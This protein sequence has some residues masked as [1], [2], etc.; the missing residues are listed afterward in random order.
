MKILNLHLI[1]FGP[2]TDTRLDLS[3]GTEGLHVIY[4]PNEAGKSSTLRGLRQMLFGI[5]DRS[6]DD[7]IH[8]YGKLRIGGA[9]RRSSGDVLDFIRRKGR[10]KTLRG[11]DDAT[12]LD[13][14]L[15][16]SFLAGVDESLFSTM[17]GIDHQG[18]V[19]GGREIING[20]GNVG[21]ILFAAGSGISDFQKVRAELTGEADDLFKPSA[22]VPRINA[23]IAEFDALKKALRAAQLP[24]QTWADHDKA[25]RD[26][27][28]RRKAVEDR[29]AEKQR[30]RNRLS[31]ITEALP[32]ISRREELRTD[33]E[34]Q[35]DA[36]LLPEDFSERRRKLFE[37]L[38]L[39]ESREEHASVSLDR[40]RKQVAGISVPVAVIER[41]GR[42]R[43]LFQEAGGVRKNARERIQLDGHRNRL[44]DDA[45]EIL[46]SLHS[47]R[48]LD[49]V[50]SLRPK[51]QD[52]RRIQELGSRFERLSTRRAA[53]RESIDR[54]RLHVNALERQLAEM[55]PVADISE[56]RQ[57]L[58]GTLRHGQLEAQYDAK[59]RDIENASAALRSE[60]ARL[61]M[62][63]GTPEALER[64]PVPSLETI[65]AFEAR[66]RKVEETIARVEAEIEQREQVLIDVQSRM[67][68]LSMS[69]EVP[70]ES[71][72]NEAREQ[73]DYGWQIV[74]EALE[75]SGDMSKQESAFLLHYPAAARM[76]DAYE[77]AVRDA[78]ALADRLRREAERVARK[79]SLLAEKEKTARSLN[80][81]KETLHGAKSKRAETLEEW[82]RFWADT[83]ITPLP[84]RE[85]H[86]WTRRQMGV[87]E[88][89]RSLRERKAS[90]EE[91][92]TLIAQCR[93][94]LLARLAAVGRPVNSPDISLYDLIG[95]ARTAIDTFEGLR[96]RRERLTADL[97]GRK[98]ELREA[99]S[100][101]ERLEQA[102]A[103]WRDEWADALRPL[104]LDART[105]PDQANAV[106]DAL[107]EMFAKLREAE[108]IDHRI[109]TIDRDF[110]A[111]ADQV[112]QLVSQAAPELGQMPPD[113]AVADLN[114]RLTSG[115]NLRTE[116]QGLLKRIQQEEA[117][118]ATARKRKAEVTAQLTAMCQEAGRET[119][120]ELPEAEARSDARRRTESQLREIEDR[121][122][123]LSGGAA[124]DAF[125]RDAS[126]ADPDAIG[127][128]MERLDKQL[129]E[130]A[131]ERTALDRTIGKEKNE[132]ERMDGNAAA[133]E[134]AVQSRSV[135]AGMERD[136]LQYI[137]LRLASEV[138]SRAIERYREKHQ[139]PILR[140]ATERFAHMTLGAFEGLRLE[141]TE[142][143]E[144]VIVG[145]RPGG[146]ET[147]RVEHMSEGTADQLYLAVRLASL[148]AYLDRKEPMPF[149]VDD[150]L[151]KFD[152]R[153][154]VAT[155]EVLAE[156]SR[157]T[158]VIFF[159][160]HRHLVELAEARIDGEVLFTHVLAGS[161]G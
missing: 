147:V 81:L 119:P 157:R 86:A 144:A 66:L 46:R 161:A 159:T 102:L 42:I 61:T 19:S 128:E 77:M 136:C 1:A 108:D 110:R 28:R 20:G 127:P 87:A 52:A 146:T 32:L 75:K 160:H 130:M 21:Q 76:T 152:D 41:E 67:A 73:R 129:Q 134:L 72:L 113:Q 80:S 3:D 123:G 143:N 18:L 16:M 114:A 9:L 132:L 8:P 89:T 115:L 65:E 6:S 103:E 111:F 15:L 17:F 155:L 140:R 90:A 58:D 95:R 154:A 62:W 84:P 2:F 88:Q 26:A 131:A 93:E 50:E 120:D 112:G 141:F 51:K 117:E 92:R 99:E 56:L 45:R 29:M 107:F 5:P 27:E 97:E 54:M 79:A 13:D 145:V 43:E 101:A 139:G 104:E 23:A 60:M 150:I 137:R 122:R 82:R 47:N 148:E 109:R 96:I 125:I 10:A 37:A 133:A 44:R 85:M 74:R 30:R 158:Q 106:I 98:A 22:R 105:S 91:V 40:L 63:E 151:I 118:L 116:Q 156:L 100:S 126:S 153:R 34:D 25:L 35:N 12:P 55:Q 121:L 33:Y 57:A 36:V 48:S 94:T 83:G 24:S 149:I 39:A 69:G 38:R 71:D 70:T 78:D 135:L 64:L 53:L 49:Q 59:A 142:K 138:L 31:R 11:P 4:G 124:L 14:S 7:F 68:E